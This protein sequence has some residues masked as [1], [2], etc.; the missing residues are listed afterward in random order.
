MPL[1]PSLPASSSLSR[2]LPIGEHQI[3]FILLGQ[4]REVVT[5]RHSVQV[6]PIGQ[7][8]TVDLSVDQDEGDIDTQFTFRAVFADA[9]GDSASSVRLQVDRADWH[10]MIWIGDT[11]NGSVHEISLQLP[12]GRHNVRV[13]VSDGLNVVYSDNLQAPLVHH[14]DAARPDWPTFQRIEA[15]I[16]EEKA[17]AIDV[18][19]VSATIRGGQQAWAVVLPTEV[20][21]VDVSGSSILEDDASPEDQAITIDSRVLVVGAGLIVLLLLALAFGGRRK[22]GR[23]GR[24]TD[25]WAAEDLWD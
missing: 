6:D 24:P 21:F 19:D 12:P 23:R 22:R 2:A 4:G 11:E 5:T 13:R 7:P 25:P 14:P 16:L 9:D 1:S 15:L 3:R 10:E 17:V 18:D 8:P 20:V